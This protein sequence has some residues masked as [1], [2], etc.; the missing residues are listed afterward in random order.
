MVTILG[1]LLDNAVEAAEKSRDKQVNI[2][3]DFRNNFSVIIISNSC[4]SIPKLDETDLPIT[5]KNN[6]KLHGF[7]L[8]SVKK[9]I[10][11]YT[12]DIGVEYNSVKKVFIVTV[13][14]DR[15]Q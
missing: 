10:K 13:M 1:N 4:D 9:T 7:G 3:T 6:R 12:G 5:T 15:K 2:E 8:K 14:L 11:K